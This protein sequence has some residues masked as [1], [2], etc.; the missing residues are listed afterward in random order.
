MKI[1]ANNK[2]MTDATFR[3]FLAAASDLA[4][5]FS[6][7]GHDAYK[8]TREAFV[9]MLCDALPKRAFIEPHFHRTPH[10]N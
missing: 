2:M 3:N 4:F 5:E 7:N 10:M 8:I 9:E 6:N 1:E